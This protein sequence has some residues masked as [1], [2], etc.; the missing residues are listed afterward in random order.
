MPRMRHRLL[1]L[2]PQARERKPPPR[3][4]PRPPTARGRWRRLSKPG[5]APTISPVPA[6]SPMPPNA[7]RPEDLAAMN[8]APAARL[9][10]LPDSLRRAA[11]KRGTRPGTGS[12]SSAGSDSRV[13]AG[14]CRALR[15]TDG[16]S[17]RFLHTFERCSPPN[18]ATPACFARSDDPSGLFPLR[19][20]RRATRRLQRGDMNPASLESIVSPTPSVMDDAYGSSDMSRAGTPA[21]ERDGPRREARTV[22]TGRASS[23]R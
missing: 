4:S 6:V 12:P 13:S 8:Q 21:P 18:R 20:F 15:H 1:R 5:R 7:V 2:R 14:G 19:R 9:D 3:R 10:D 17:R 23:W 11:M 16:L 22:L